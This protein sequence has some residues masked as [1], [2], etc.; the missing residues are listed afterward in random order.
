MGIEKQLVIKLS[1]SVILQIGRPVSPLN[2]QFKLRRLF[3]ANYT[4]GGLRHFR[5]LN[6]VFGEQTLGYLSRLQ[7]DSNG[8]FCNTHIFPLASDFISSR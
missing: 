7:I 3:L 5:Q 4:A 2:G 6:V 1:Y 8:R